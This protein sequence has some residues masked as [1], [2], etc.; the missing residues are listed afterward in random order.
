MATS[1]SIGAYRF[2]IYYELS[3]RPG[4]H[5]AI[6]HRGC[7]ELR[8]WFNR[9]FAEEFACLTVLEMSQSHVPKV[10]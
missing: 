4:L 6:L 8:A 10:V 9:A 5:W 3:G 2:S 1:L 7:V